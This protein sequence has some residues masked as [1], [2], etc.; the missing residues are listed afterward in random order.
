VESKIVIHFKIY[1]KA[2]EYLSKEK[3]KIPG[4]KEKKKLTF[5]ERLKLRNCVD[6]E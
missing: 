2:I 6:P 3:E 5:A 1:L 4:K